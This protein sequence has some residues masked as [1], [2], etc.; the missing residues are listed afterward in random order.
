MKLKLKNV[1]LF[2]YEN[3]DIQLAIDTI[4]I[5]KFYADFGSIKFI[6][7]KK[8]DY[9][10]AVY[11]SFNVNSLESY[12]NF[13][14]KKLNIYIETDYALLIQTDG[15]ILNSE[16]WTDEFYDYDYI[17]APWFFNNPPTVGNGGFSLRSRKL[18]NALHIILP[19]IDYNTL[20]PHED[21]VICVQLRHILENNFKIK[22]APVELADRFSVETKGKW[23]P[24]TFGF[25]N[26]KFV[27][28]EKDGWI[29]PLKENTCISP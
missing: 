15:H 20:H 9:E 21:Y 13:I 17:G 2:I 10:H 6:S 8:I 16:A 3:R 25:H 23:Y 1:T 27:N 12:S 24:T 4:N 26:Y 18:L 28:P 29:D 11:D 14:L 5:C 22:F 7:N 19:N